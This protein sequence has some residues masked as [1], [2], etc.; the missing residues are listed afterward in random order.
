MFKKTGA[1]TGMLQ[2]FKNIFYL[3]IKEL[4]GLFRDYMMV[5]LIAYSFSLGVWVSGSA[6]PDS[7][8]NAVIAVVG[9]NR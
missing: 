3:G 5:V 2:S 6:S 1:L 8:T 9:M 4:R 7:L